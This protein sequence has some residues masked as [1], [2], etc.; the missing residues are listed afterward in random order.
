MSA[1]LNTIFSEAYS[2]LSGEVFLTQEDVPTLKAF[3]AGIKADVFVNAPTVFASVKEKLDMAEKI[4]CE[5]RNELTEFQA[6]TAGLWNE[7]IELWQDEIEREGD[8]WDSKVLNRKISDS[9]IIDY[10]RRELSFETHPEDIIYDDNQKIDSFLEALHRLEE[11]T[12]IEK[13]WQRKEDSELDELLRESGWTY[14]D[15]RE[16]QKLESTKQIKKLNEHPIN[17]RALEILDEVGAARAARTF[18]PQLHIVELLVW[19]EE[20][21]KLKVELEETISRNWNILWFSN[22]NSVSIM[23]EVMYNRWVRTAPPEAVLLENLEL[24]GIEANRDLI[25]FL[26]QRQQKINFE[27]PLTIE[28]AAKGIPHTEHTEYEELEKLRGAMCAYWQAE[29]KP[30]PP[31]YEIFTTLL[32]AHGLLPLSPKSPQYEELTELLKEKQENPSY[33]ENQFLLWSWNLRNIVDYAEYDPIEVMR[34]LQGKDLEPES[35]H[36]QD[37]QDRMTLFLTETQDE[38]VD[39]VFLLLEFIQ[40]IH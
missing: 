36:R 2:Q 35:A 20:M 7:E 21:E 27:Y 12:R 24:L 1:P 10:L 16:L 14:E 11:R 26:K 23:R 4:Y 13:T 38:L 9:K 31:E 8:K 18:T 3:L 17:Q 34:R 32:V 33:I 29:G 6:Q 22:G 39:T 19:V 40:L 37:I 5:A 15:D 28:E 25:T 30:E